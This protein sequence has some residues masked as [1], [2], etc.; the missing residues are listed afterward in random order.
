MSLGNINGRDAS[1]IRHQVLHASSAIHRIQTHFTLMAFN[2][3]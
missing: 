1:C 3:T 2:C